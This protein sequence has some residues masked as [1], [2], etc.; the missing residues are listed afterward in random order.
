MQIIAHSN[1]VT[2]YQSIAIP[3]SMHKFM[4]R[5]NNDE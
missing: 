5:G 1:I 2:I 4:Q 3:S